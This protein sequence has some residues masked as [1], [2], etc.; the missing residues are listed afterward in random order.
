MLEAQILTNIHRIETKPVEY[1]QQLKR[2]LA[3]NPMMTESE[4]AAKL[5]KSP[6]WIKERLG[7]AKISNP[8]IAAAINEGKI[9]L[10]NAYALAKLPNEEQAAFVDRAIS[11]TP[12]EFLPAVNG[13]VKEIREAKRKGTDPDSHT[14]QPVPFLQKLGD[15]KA[16]AE[17]SQIAK[18]VCFQSNASTAVE[19]FKAALAW[20]LHL[21]PASIAEQ[22]AKEEARQAEKA[23]AKKRRDEEKAA[24]KAK[25]AAS[26]A[27]GAEG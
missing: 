18:T 9:G 17:D 23:E 24:A 6:T 16:A 13:R 21:D 26:I 2:I 15:I 12:E 22:V 27:A 4:L 20:A 3:R 1:S 19:G 7:L 11:S 5:C 14:F 8:E 10:A 25:Q